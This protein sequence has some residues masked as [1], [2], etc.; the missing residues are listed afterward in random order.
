MWGGE[1]EG[2]A[3]RALE[4]CLNKGPEVRELGHFGE[5]LRH[6]SITGGTKGKALEPL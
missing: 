5:L 2:R 1:K 3:S 6:G 4:K